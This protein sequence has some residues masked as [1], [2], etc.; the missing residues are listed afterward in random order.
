M[1][2]MVALLRVRVGYGQIKKLGVKTFI[3]WV[4]LWNGMLWKA[5]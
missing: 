3:K 2:A 4:A 1:V 5:E